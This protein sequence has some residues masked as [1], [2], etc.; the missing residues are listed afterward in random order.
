MAAALS[1]LIGSADPATA[2]ASR[3]ATP[4]QRLAVTALAFSAKSVNATAGNATVR[5]SWTITDS[6]AGVNRITGGLTL[7]AP[8]KIAGSYL[9][10]RITVPFALHGKARVGGTARRSSYANTFSVPRYARAS[11]VSWEVISLT[12]QDNKGDKLTLGTPR[13]AHFRATL[14]AREIAVTTG[15]TFDTFGLYDP[16]RPYAYSGSHGSGFQVYNMC[17]YPSQ[18]GF[19]AGTL[20]L[21]GPAGHSFTSQFSYN[22]VAP[23]CMNPSTRVQGQQYIVQVKFPVGLTPGIW[24]V[25]A[26]QL[27]DT[28]GNVTTASNLGA[29]VTVTAD[30]VLTASDFIAT[31]NPANDWAQAATVTVSI[32]VSGVTA[33]VSTIYLDFAGN[34]PGD[35][36]GSCRDYSGPASTGPGQESVQFQ[37]TTLTKS[38]QVTGIAIVDGAGDL[39]LYGSEYG[40]PDPGLTVSQTPDTTPPTATS[41]SLSPGGINVSYWLAIGVTTQVAPVAGLDLRIYNADGVL[42]TSASTSGG[43]AQQQPPQTGA[44]TVNYPVDTTSL[45]PG[46]Y[47]VAFTLFD[48]ANQASSYGEGGSNPMPGGPLTFTVP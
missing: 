21:S 33:G 4:V 26:L 25:S 35:V 15:P 38:C 1:G 14:G 9:T 2:T 48:A 5:L 6:R 34:Y 36:Q 8:G 42:Q 39:A 7:A 31:P 41:A 23:E 27:M 10:E 40:A 32:N 44:T 46:T 47:T 28:A 45:P 17:I 29:P 13:L 20:R 3:A 22:Q 12:A 30:Q 18:A 24:T 37:M 16:V 11:Q 19:T 43:V